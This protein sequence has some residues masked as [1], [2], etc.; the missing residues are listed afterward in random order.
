MAS[1]VCFKLITADKYDISGVHN[2]NSI[3]LYGLTLQP[4]FA[5]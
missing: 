4:K 3:P 5:S 1:G 2:Q